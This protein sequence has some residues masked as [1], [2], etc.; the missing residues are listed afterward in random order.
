MQGSKANVIEGIASLLTKLPRNRLF[1]LDK[2]G[3]VELQTTYYDA[4]LSKILADQ[5]RNVALRW[6]NKS[7]IETDVRPDAII[8]KLVQHAFSQSIGF[9]EVKVGNTSTTK[10]S[11]CLNVVRLGIICKR[12]IDPAIFAGCI[13]FLIHG[14]HLS[15]FMVRKEK[16]Q[17][18]TMAE[19]ASLDMAPSLTD[20]HVFASLKNI[21]MLAKISR[22]FWC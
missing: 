10:H 21:N 8:S 4:L 6:A 18:D 9:G 13:A 3:E 15:F 14:F 17:F 1:D 22:S 12:A 11:V 16:H 2:I 20:L 19:I 5:D 7:D